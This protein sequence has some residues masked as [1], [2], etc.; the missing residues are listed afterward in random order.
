[1]FPSV[2]NGSLK[3]APKGIDP[4][5]QCTVKVEGGAGETEPM[6]ASKQEWNTEFQLYQI[7]I[8]PRQRILT[9]QQSPVSEYTSEVEVSLNTSRVDLVTQ[10]T[11]WIKEA[12]AT[13]VR[14]TSL[15]KKK[16]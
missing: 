4:K 13:F 12:T 5:L 10:E 14:I 9:F 16:N 7:L 3:S 6:A 2:Q 8:P 1:L 15:T 11:R